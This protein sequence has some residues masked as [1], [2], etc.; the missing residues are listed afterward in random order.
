MLNL[1]DGSSEEQSSAPRWS[2]LRALWSCI[3][4]QVV[5]MWV[6]TGDGASEGSGLIQITSVLLCLCDLITIRSHKVHF[7]ASCGHSQLLLGGSV[8]QERSHSAQL[9][10]APVK[11]CSRLIKLQLLQQ[12]PGFEYKRFEFRPTAPVTICRN[13]SLLTGESVECLSFLW[14]ESLPSEDWCGDLTWDLIW[15]LSR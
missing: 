9:F 5:K 10:K 1:E 2:C 3:S 8:S 7:N 15:T 4:V 14:C 12:I 11:L 13:K 6:K